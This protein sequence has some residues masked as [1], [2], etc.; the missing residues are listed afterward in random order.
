MGEFVRTA[1]TFPA[2]IFGFLLVVVVG[3]WVL[4]LVSGAGLDGL[5]ADGDPGLGAG[6]LGGLGLGGMPVTVSVSLLV[7]FSWFIGLAGTAL[8]DGPAARVAVLAAAPAG[9]WLA[10][11]ALAAPLRRMGAAAPAPSRADFVGRT[12][13]IRTGR[14]GADFGQAEV[15]ASDGSSAVI[16]VRQLQWPGHPPRDEPGGLPAR[17]GHG[18]VPSTAPDRIRDGRHA[19][20]AGG[21]HEEP[22]RAGD[23]AL[24]FEYDAEREFFWVTPCPAGLGPGAPTT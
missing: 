9:A 16:Q 6:L 10:V 1:L 15:R 18:P 17:G 22:L 7:A 12:C 13:V 3:Y 8:V 23:L 19:P 2:V 20:A 11:R 14:V 4:V 24:I 21:H 5:G